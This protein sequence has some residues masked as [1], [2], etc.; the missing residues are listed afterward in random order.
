[1]IRRTRLLFPTLRKKREG[2]DTLG[3]GVWD[4]NEQR[5]GLPQVLRLRYAQDDVVVGDGREPRTGSIEIGS[6]QSHK[7]IFTVAITCISRVLIARDRL[8]GRIARDGFGSTADARVSRLLIQ[9]GSNLL[10]AVFV[11]P[12]AGAVQSVLLIC[13]GI[14]ETVEHWLPDRSQAGP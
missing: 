6:M 3:C 5:Q 11:T 12:A 10:D 7:F 9:S 13:H 4:E 1:L 14:G 2:W 8:L